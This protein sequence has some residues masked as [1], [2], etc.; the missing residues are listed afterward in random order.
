ML[1]WRE[2]MAYPQNVLR[3]IARK[4][5]DTEWV[6]LADVDIVPIPSLSDALEQFLATS[7]ATKCKK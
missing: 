2:K 1:Q 6:F 5:C 3:N 4:N 7:P